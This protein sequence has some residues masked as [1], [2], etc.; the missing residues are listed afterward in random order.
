MRSRWL[1]LFSLVA[2]RDDSG[3]CL[4]LDAGEPRDA[5]IDAACPPSFD[6]LSVG[7]AGMPVVSATGSWFL[8]TTAGDTF[9]HFSVTF[10]RS[11]TP[12]VLEFAV[13]EATSGQPY[14]TGTPNDFDP[15][16]VP[17]PRTAYSYFVE[18]LKAASYGRVWWASNGSITLNNIGK[19]A[20]SMVDGTVSATMYREV[21][22]MTGA[23]LPSGC[24]LSLAA[25]T[26]WL[27][28][29]VDAF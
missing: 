26:F 11:H 16:P 14:L 8:T 28:Q 4:C 5:P 10:E 9:F 27:K 17:T 7:S 3:H 6:T 1:A 23:D 24:T 18:D 22:I 21:D 20:G 25:L 12:D 15:N 19:T 13:R 2:C 29:D